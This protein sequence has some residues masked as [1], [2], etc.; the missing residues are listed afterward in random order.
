MINE[1]FVFVGNNDIKS[2]IKWKPKEL[3]TEE[4]S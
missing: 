1:Y 4:T 2:N 3:G